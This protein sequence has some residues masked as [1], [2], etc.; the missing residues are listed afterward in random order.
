MKTNLLPIVGTT[1]VLAG[2]MFASSA[3][4]VVWDVF[5]KDVR[6]VGIVSVSDIIGAASLMRA[7]NE[8]SKAGYA[9]KVMPN[10]SGPKQVSAA[11]RARYFEEAWL[12]PSVDLLMFS[13][14]GKGAID[15][16][17]VINWEKL[18]ARDMRV[19]GY[20]DLTLVL[21]TM[22]RKGVGHPLTGPMISTLGSLKTSDEARLR[23]RATLDGT[24]KETQLR[25]VRKASGVIVGKPMGGLLDRVWKLAERGLLPSAEG[26]IV[27]LENTPKYGGKAR[28]ML[29]RLI[30][31][32]VFDKAVAVVFCDFN[33]NDPAE[34]VARVFSDF[35]N[36]VECPVYCGYP[37]GHVANNYLLDFKMQMAI[38]LDDRIVKAPDK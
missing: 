11:E 27:F 3:S 33:R 4:A 14:G 28:R 8:L 24:P 9:V 20:S 30:E 17:D 12:D 34:D 22:V 18:K 2:C 5:P 35:A 13:T 26:R 25:A 7:T 15:V 32:S 21:N 1:A 29:D 23:M 16:I 37:Y 31:L 10:V 6:T 19:I 38:T 36:K